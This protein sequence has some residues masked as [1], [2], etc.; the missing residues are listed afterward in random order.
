MKRSL[1]FCFLLLGSPILMSESCEKRKC[2]P[3][4]TCTEEF[5]MVTVRV[6]DANGVPISLDDAYTLR[7]GSAETLRFESGGVGMYTVLDDSYRQRLQNNIDDFFFIAIKNGKKIAEERF[8]VG[9]DC[10]H[11]QKVSGTEKIVVNP[12][13]Q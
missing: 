2:P 10:C 9:A 3:D 12:S 8:V 13:A 4:V 11:V 7:K 1:P 6:E 5:A